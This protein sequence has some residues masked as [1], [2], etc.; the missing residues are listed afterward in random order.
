MSDDRQ[1]RA[2]LAFALVF[3]TVITLLYFVVLARWLPGVAV[4]AY[5]PL[6][7]CQF[8]FPLWWVFVRKREALA[9]APATNKPQY[10]SSLAL[11]FAFGLAVMLAMLAGY[12]WWLKPLGLFDGHVL[13]QIKAKTASFR[14]SSPAAFFACAAFYALVHSLLEEYYWRWFV[15]R[16]CRGL[17]RLPAAISVSSLGFAAHHVIVL[18][19]YFGF[20]GPTTYVFALAV[21]MGGA[22]WAWLYEKFSTLLGPWLSHLLI[23]A[24]IFMVGYDLLFRTP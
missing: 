4:F 2:A 16:Q 3:P 10:S 7:L 15:F 6:K 17:W 12:A 13:A 23:D 9:G 8:A 1:D 20:D 21:A 14:L 19:E 22:A 5:A 11:G 18:G 24:A